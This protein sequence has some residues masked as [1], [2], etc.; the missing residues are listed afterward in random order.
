MNLQGKKIYIYYFLKKLIIY[1]KFTNIIIT[2]KTY[3]TYLI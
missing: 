3:K 1:I 2:Y